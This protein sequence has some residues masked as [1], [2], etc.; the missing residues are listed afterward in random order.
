M[1]ELAL[2][3]LDI[4]ENSVSAGASTVEIAVNEN[5]QEDELWITVQDNGKGMDEDLLVSVLNPFSTSRTER[6]VG[7]GIPMLKQAAE[8]CAGFL[9][10]SS[11]KGL[12]TRINAKFQ[13]SHI[14]RMPL[15]D[16]ADS[17]LT[18]LFGTPE[19][20][21]ILNYQVNDQSFH[22]DD[23]EVKQI[24]EGVPLTDYR[25]IKILTTTIRGGIDKTYEIGSKQGV[26]HAH[27]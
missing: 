26:S 19:V 12:G 25:I 23:T 22:F 18:L 15:G 16:L 7:L 20:N 3:I 6:K 21:W 14:D 8:A 11:A 17:F 5:I 24:L 27:N 10:I 9:E 2:H 4:A 13:H 1:R